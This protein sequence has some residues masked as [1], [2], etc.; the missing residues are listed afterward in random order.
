[1]TS[2]VYTRR[3][4]AAS[5]LAGAATATVPAGRVWIVTDINGIARSQVGP[6]AEVYAAVGNI[7]FSYL[8]SLDSDHPMMQWRGKQVLVA[9]EVLTVNGAGGTVDVTVIGYDLTA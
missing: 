2:P 6:H 8:E 9:G 3:L 1:M 7:L 4:L 5:Q